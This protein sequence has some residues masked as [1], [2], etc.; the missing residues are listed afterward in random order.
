L[1]DGVAF[2]TSAVEVVYSVAG[3]AGVVTADA[4][5]RSDVVELES[6][7]GAGA[8]NQVE[9]AV[10]AGEAAVDVDVGASCAGHVASDADSVG[11]EL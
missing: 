6:C 10:G 3:V 7:A 9:G 1:D 8:G 5:V 11:V 4:G 2:A